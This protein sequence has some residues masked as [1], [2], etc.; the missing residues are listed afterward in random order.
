MMVT[1]RIC[2]L[3][4]LHKSNGIIKLQLSKFLSKHYYKEIILGLRSDKMYLNNKFEAAIYYI[5]S[6]FVKS[7][8]IETG[9]F[10][11]LFKRA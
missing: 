4:P 2:S 5:G 6:C 1:I 9:S 3:S 10:T 7:Y 11:N 8:T